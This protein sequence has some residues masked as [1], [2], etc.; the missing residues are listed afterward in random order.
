[1]RIELR[2]YGVFR[3]NRFAEQARELAPGTL[4]QAVV[5]SLQLPDHLLGIVLINGVHG[6]LEDELRDGDVLSLLP[7]VDGG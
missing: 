7:I 4:V 2:L 3:R 6:R 1:M 5:Q